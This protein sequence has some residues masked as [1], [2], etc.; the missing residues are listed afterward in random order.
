M[1]DPPA[2]SFATMMIPPLPDKENNRTSTRLVL[3]KPSLSSSTRL[4][5]STSLLRLGESID[6]FF[7][8]KATTPPAIRAQ[9]NVL[10]ENPTNIDAWY[11]V[12]DHIASSLPTD[13]CLRLYRRATAKLGDLGSPKVVAIW[14]AYARLQP[15]SEARATLRHV[16][17]SCPVLPAAYYTTLANVQVSAGQRD[18]AVATLEIGLQAE[19]EPVMDLQAALERLDSP[20]SKRRRTDIEDDGTES[21]NMSLG[22]D[23]T[24]VNDSHESTTLHAE[25]EEEEE[26]AAPMVHAVPATR[27]MLD[28]TMRPRPTTSAGREASSS[29]TPAVTK[30]LGEAVR[31]ATSPRTATRPAVTSQSSVRER[32]F[33]SNVAKQVQ[34]VPTC[35]QQDASRQSASAVPTSLALSQSIPAFRAKTSTSNRPPLRFQPPG[36]TRLRPGNLGKAQRV[37][38]SQYQANDDDSD[39]DND[40]Q[41]YSFSS[42]PSHDPSQHK[43]TKITKMDLSYM[44]DWDPEKHRSAQPPTMERID[45]GP[46]SLSSSTGSGE[47]QP[48]PAPP[49]EDTTSDAMVASKEQ[50]ATTQEAV[51]ATPNPV[52]ATHT[53]LPRSSSLPTSAEPTT[54]ASALVARSNAD[55]L[56]L[57]SES[58]MLR[59][60]GVPYA[61]LGV[62]GKGGSCKV[63]RALS[64]DCSVVAIKK[65][66]LV[67]MDKRS[68]SGYANEIALLK[69]LRGNP[70]IIQMTDSE[71][72][73]KRKAIFV[74]MELGE[75]DLNHV[76]QQQQAMTSR[77]GRRNLNMNFIRLTWQQ[78][79]SAVH[80]IHEARIVHGDLKP[81]N[82]LFVRGALKLIDFGIAKAIQ[83]DD[84][85]N[86]YR[87]SQIGTLNYMSPEAIL[88]SGTGTNGA[89]MKIGRASDIWSLGCI[90]YQMVYGKTPFAEL[91]MIQKLQAIV[92]PHHQIQFPW[93][94]DKGAKDAIQQCLRRK[95]EERP[96]IVGAGGLL[97]EHKFLHS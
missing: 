42:A 36:R 5:S 48:S 2:P 88:D 43:P 51:S 13:H 57:V 31:R 19:A 3:G 96:P 94:I 53:K 55:F 68:I 29:P 71:V 66:K 12:L 83:S 72:D 39:E 95:P 92:D 54:E 52:T 70:A 4:A 16:Q 17:R 87:E 81:A 18:A 33:Q 69:R 32:L 59:V 91:H 67:G 97:S 77:G 79:L 60:N 14:L 10:V 75:V 86:I 84:T 6:T 40:T 20:S 21:S 45:E 89:R 35:N 80:C 9:A 85:T 64:K 49:K 41:A 61:K 37:D 93:S 76:L 34:P 44:W 78:M 22:T 82:F 65:V 30:P 28:L 1:V 90:L 62:V 8:F 56:P 25:E 15:E 50:P 47:H 24:S 58:N 27:P 63:Y 38:P 73:L 46:P 11:D 26:P 23:G 7:G 74:V